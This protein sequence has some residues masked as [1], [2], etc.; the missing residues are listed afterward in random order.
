MRKWGN[1]L[2]FKTLYFVEDCIHS[3]FNTRYFNHILIRVN[4][5]LQHF[6]TSVWSI[7]HLFF[8]SFLLCIVR[9]FYSSRFFHN[10]CSNMAPNHIW[11]VKLQRSRANVTQYNHKN[12]VTQMFD[13]SSYTNLVALCPMYHPTGSQGIIM[14]NKQLTTRMLFNWRPWKWAKSRFLQTP[15]WSSEKAQLFNLLSF[16]FCTCCPLLICRPLRQPALWGWPGLTL[17]LP[18]MA[19]K[20]SLER[21]FA[22]PLSS[23]GYKGV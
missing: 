18:W 16:H 1:N 6:F 9:F 15:G 2:L 8:F 12:N 17:F 13:L 11:Q 5:R 3:L 23:Q 21:Y 4:L 10:T 14:K 7:S 19:Q 20:S 22:R